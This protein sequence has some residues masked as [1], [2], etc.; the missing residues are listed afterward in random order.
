M[1]RQETRGRKSTT[2]TLRVLKDPLILCNVRFAF[3]DDRFISIHSS[4]STHM[5]VYL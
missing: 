2:E 3:G 4:D 1:Y 5:A